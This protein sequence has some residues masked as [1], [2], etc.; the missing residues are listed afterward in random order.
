MGKFV[1]L[2]K[3]PTD[4]KAKKC[5][6]NRY[7]HEVKACSHNEWNMHVKSIYLYVSVLVCLSVY[8]FVCSLTPLKWLGVIN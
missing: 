7:L 8:T 1:D 6:E 3:L 2:L 5:L 4:L